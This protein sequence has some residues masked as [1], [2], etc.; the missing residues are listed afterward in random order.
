ME[1]FLAE[2]RDGKIPEL[3]VS[4]FQQ[5]ASYVLSRSY[6]TTS[7]PIPVV[8]PDTTRTAKFNITSGNFLDLGSLFF[9]YTVRN[10]SGQ[11]SLYPVSA[12]GATFWRRMILF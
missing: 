4:A 12:L 9:S 5:Q 6:T 3:D 10:E 7:C 2:G 1:S 11:N 8:A